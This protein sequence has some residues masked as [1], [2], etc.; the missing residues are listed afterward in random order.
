MH[1]SVRSLSL[2][3]LLIARTVVQYLVHNKGVLLRQA[4]KI[5]RSLRHA[6]VV[7]PWPPNDAFVFVFDIAVFMVANFEAVTLS[8]SPPPS[9]YSLLGG[10]NADFSPL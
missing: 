10:K 3:N 4:L 6:R 9:S 5:S 1:R 7:M 8:R 2:G